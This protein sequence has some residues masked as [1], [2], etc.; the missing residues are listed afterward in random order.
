MRRKSTAYLKYEEVNEGLVKG[1]NMFE[2]REYLTLPLADNDPDGIQQEEGFDK[3]GGDFG[4]AVCIVDHEISKNLLSSYMKEVGR[5][6]LLTAEE[7]KALAKEIQ[8]TQRNLIRRLLKLDLKIDEIHLLTRK[9]RNISDDL[10]AAIV[11]KLEE[12]KRES[13]ISH[14]KIAF[15][16]ETSDLYGRLS[17]LKGEMLKRNLRLVVKIAR[18]YLYSGISLSDLVQEGNLGLMRAVTKFDY[19]RGCRFS[20]YATWW[21]RQ[22]ILRAKVEKER[23]IRI[24]IHLMEKRRKLAKT[25]RN[26]LKKRGKQPQPEEIAKKAKVPLKVVH[27]AL[28]PLPQTVSFETSVGEGSNLEYLI[29]DEK[30]PSPFEVMEREEVRQMVEKALS[31]LPPREAEVLR[32]RFGIGGDGEHT[33]QEIGR[34]FGISRERVRQLEKKAINRLRHWKKR[35]AGK[36][37]KNTGSNVQPK[38]LF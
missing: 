16:S 28:F 14:H 11:A 18:E 6:T 2:I 36:N 15:L 19:K 24:P 32:L 22:A 23:T 12:L 1:T 34:K 4:Q 35:V 27:K 37:G 3:G 25:C 20:T 5:I 10:L 26:F 29:K 7:E 8:E 33:L 30:S 17:Q 13:K 31:H 38:T 9:K 21:I